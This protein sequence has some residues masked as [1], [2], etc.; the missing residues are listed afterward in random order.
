MAGEKRAMRRCSA[1]SAATSR[2]KP[3]R[4]AGR[5]ARSH[6]AAMTDSPALTGITVREFDVLAAPRAVTAPDLVAVAR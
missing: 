6:P 4:S 5:A 2:P 1:A 3:P